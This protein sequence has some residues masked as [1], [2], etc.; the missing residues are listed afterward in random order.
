MQLYIYYIL[1]RD[2]S[3]V[4]KIDTHVHHSVNLF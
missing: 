1:K 4:R 3:N 2:F